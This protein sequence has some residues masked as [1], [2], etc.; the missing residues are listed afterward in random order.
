[1]TWK[2]WIALAFLIQACESPQNYSVEYR[3]SLK[4]IMHEGN[5]SATIA[6]DSL[7]NRDHLYALGAA[8][9]LDGEILIWN[10]RPLT[11]HANGDSLSID[12]T[13]DP[14]AALLVFVSVP[15]WKEM[16]LPESVKTIA[17]LENYIKETL[18]NPEFPVSF[19]I[20]GEIESLNWHVVR[21]GNG[22][23]LLPHDQHAQ[24][25]I[26]GNLTGVGVNILGF[27]SSKHQGVFTHHSS[28]VHMHV[29][30]DDKKTSA[31]V[32]EVLFN[33]QAKIFLPE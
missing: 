11:A 28:N 24:S 20:T 14:K 23:E 19:L 30:T 7:K 29:T 22:E 16:L 9:N 10:S 3:G 27:Y 31:H 33:G 17:D 15:K 4:S 18:N 5:T 21:P 13:F 26:R 2:R 8:E 6:L 25:G 12:S 1:M 32:D